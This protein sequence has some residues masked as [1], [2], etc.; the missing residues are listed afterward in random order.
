MVQF[1]RTVRVSPLLRRDRTCSRSPR[2]V[3]SMGVERLLPRLKRPGC[4]A[5]QSPASTSEV[6]N[7]WS[8]TRHFLISSAQDAFAFYVSVRYIIPIR[9]KYIR[10]F[11]TT[12][13]YTV[14]ANNTALLTYLLT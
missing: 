13:T 6:R 4:E 10:N 9:N 8:Y 12:A 11:V 14:T 3:Y 1:Q 7:A 5:K 2:A